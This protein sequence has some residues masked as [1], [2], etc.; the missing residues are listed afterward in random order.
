MVCC[1]HDACP[2]SVL[3]VTSEN[4]CK[5]LEKLYFPISFLSLLLLYNKS[6][7]LIPR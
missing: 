6:D 5:I 3:G 2:Y 1:L 4:P 7:Q